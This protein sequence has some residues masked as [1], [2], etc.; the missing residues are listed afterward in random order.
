MKTI[1]L[2]VYRFIIIILVL[3]FQ[4]CSTTK[5]IVV[6]N[7]YYQDIYSIDYN[8]PNYSSE[9]KNISI[10]EFVNKTAYG[11]RRLGSS[12]SDILYNELVKSGKFNVI[13]REKLKVIIDELTLGASGLLDESQVIELGKLS[14]SEIIITGSVSQFGSRIEGKDR[15]FYET[16]SQIIEAIVDIRLIDV[17]SSNIITAYT[18]KGLVNKTIRSFMGIGSRG[19]YDESLEGETLRASIVDVVKQIENDDKLFSLLNE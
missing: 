18:G 6:G 8:S 16:K 13:E 10:M 15:F 1:F 5:Y 9:R 17:E 3:Y 7:E 11:K 19:R 4:G 2:S 14:G 12:A